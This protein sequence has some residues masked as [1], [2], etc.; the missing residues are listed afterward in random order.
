[1]MKVRK[2]KGG[3]LLRLEKG[4]EVI[5]SLKR[6]VSDEGIK[7]GIIIGIGAIEDIK[8]GYYDPVK[9]E[10]FDKEFKGSHELGNLTGNISYLNGEPLIHIHATISSSALSAYTGHLSSARISLTAEILILTFDAELSRK[11]D[12]ETGL[13]LWDI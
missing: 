1:M 6:L 9:K 7:S 5:S 3:Y 10:H 12:P 13:N 11:H 8:L 2:V 4:E